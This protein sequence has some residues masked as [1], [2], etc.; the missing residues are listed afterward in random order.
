MAAM[1]VVN[2]SNWCLAIGEG[3]YMVLVSIVVLSLNCI[4]IFNFEVLFRA[5]ISLLTH[6]M[7]PLMGLCYFIVIGWFR[8]WPQATAPSVL[9]NIL[10]WH[11]RITCPLLMLMVFYNVI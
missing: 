10:K 2:Q 9:A 1:S 11:I 6:F 8:D 4:I 7:L 3:P 5:V